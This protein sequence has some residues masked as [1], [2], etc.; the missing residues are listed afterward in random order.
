MI[1]P[2]IILVSLYIFLYIIND[3]LIPKLLRCRLVKTYHTFSWV[4]GGVQ[5]VDSLS[6]FCLDWQGRMPELKKK[7]RLCVRS[8]WKQR[9]KK[10]QG[11]WHAEFRGYPDIPAW[12][13]RIS[14]C[15]KPTNKLGFV[16]SD[17]YPG[18]SPL[19]SDPRTST[20][21]RRLHEPG[22]PGGDV[23]PWTPYFVIIG[24]WKWGTGWIMNGWYH[25]I[26]SGKLT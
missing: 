19:W 23:A 21:R 12:S 24:S 22:L 3:I 7:P 6:G 5:L 11:F 2:Y 9:Q 26:P 16:D 4:E 13:Q 17:V 10:E 15:T 20:D 14:C 8:S 1:I 25:E 18:V